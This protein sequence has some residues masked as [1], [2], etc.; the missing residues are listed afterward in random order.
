MTCTYGTLSYSCMVGHFSSVC[1]CVTRRS[2]NHLLSGTPV[3]AWLAVLLSDVTSLLEGGTASAAMRGIAST[4]LMKYHEEMNDLVCSFRSRIAPHLRRRVQRQ[5]GCSLE[6]FQAELDLL[7]SK[8]REDNMSV[9]ALTNCFTDCVLLADDV[10]S[11][12]ITF[13]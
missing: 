11:A 3:D 12:A 1:V 5:L 7:Q 6:N 8:R 4:I 2:D 9:Q 13:Q 10:S